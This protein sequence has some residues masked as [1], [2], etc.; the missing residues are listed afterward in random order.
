MNLALNA[1]KFHYELVLGMP[2]RFYSIERPRKKQLLPEVL[3]TQEIKRMIDATRNIKHKCILSLLYSAGL[4]RGE[5]L[6]LIPSDIKSN[7]MLILVR[8]AKGIRIGTPCSAK[9]HL[10]NYANTIGNTG[11]STFYLRLLMTNLT[12]VPA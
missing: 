7:R 1:I 11:Q 5:L 4:R 9:P 3:S 12:V 2:N 10:S 6:N 8:N